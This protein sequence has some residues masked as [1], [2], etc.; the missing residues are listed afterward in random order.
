MVML[1]MFRECLVST[2]IPSSRFSWSCCFVVSKKQIILLSSADPDNVVFFSRPSSPTIST[3]FPILTESRTSTHPSSSSLSSAARRAFQTVLNGEAADPMPSSSSPFPLTINTPLR[4]RDKMSIT[5]PFSSS[6]PQ[7]VHRCAVSNVP[8]HFDASTR[9]CRFPP[10]M[11]TSDPRFDVPHWFDSDPLPKSSLRRLNVKDA[12]D[13]LASIQTAPPFPPDEHEWKEV[14][15]ISSD[16]LSRSVTATAPPSAAD[17]QF[18]NVDF[19]MTAVAVSVR[20]SSTVPFIFPTILSNVLSDTST[21][22]FDSIRAQSV[23]SRSVTDI[24]FTRRIPP[25]IKTS[26]LSNSDEHENEQAVTIS[27]PL[28]D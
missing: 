22:P 4:N 18:L 28:V 15:R 6:H 17:S 26:S 27:V 16:A 25:V 14:V 12:G 3:F 13:E 19:V 7:S 8:S 2:I 5:L 1:S 9:V 24:S 20:V 21:F 11:N 23:I 10:K